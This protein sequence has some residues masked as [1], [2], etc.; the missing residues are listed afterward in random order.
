MRPRGHGVGRTAALVILLCCLSG[1]L[2]GEAAKSSLPGIP[3]PV[4][5]LT[6][7][8]PDLQETI[9]KFVQIPVCMLEMVLGKVAEIST[10]GECKPGGLP[11]IDQDK[12]KS[13]GVELEVNYGVVQLGSANAA[14]LC[15]Y[16][17]AAENVL[18]EVR[19]QVEK[20]P[21]LGVGG[22]FPHELTKLLEAPVQTDSDS[23]GDDDDGGG[24]GDEGDEDSQ[25][26][27]G[28]DDGD[29]DEGGGESEGPGEEGDEGDSETS[30]GAQSGARKGTAKGKG[31]AKKSKKSK[32]TKG[33]KNGK[34]SK[35]TAVLTASKSRF[36][37]VKRGTTKTLRDLA[38][39]IVWAQARARRTATGEFHWLAVRGARAVSSF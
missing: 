17:M 8:I 10:K 26:G 23:G 13:I 32:K 25:G 30:G 37:E 39:D 6:G 14:E 31:A 36:R 11:E 15:D 12:L 29:G 28:G 9:G 16:V 21:D 34:K 27:E 5:M 35:A 4:K 7:G 18:G 1:P 2:V 19:K 24:E 3:N 22:C 33:K 38:M 20:G